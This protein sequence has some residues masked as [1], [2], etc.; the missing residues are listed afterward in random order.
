M[1]FWYLLDTNTAAYVIR[2]NIPS[3]RHHLIG[4][5]CGYRRRVALWCVAAPWC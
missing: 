3:V 1:T 5:F 4:Y 2:G